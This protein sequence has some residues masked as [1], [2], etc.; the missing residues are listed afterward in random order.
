MARKKKEGGRK[1]RGRERGSKQDGGRRESNLLVG[2]E[3]EIK[4]GR[5]GIKEEKRESRGCHTAVIMD[6]ALLRMASEQFAR[7]SPEQRAA[8]QAQMANMDPAMSA[9]M[10]DK[11]SNMKKDDINAAMNQMHNMSPE[12]MATAAQAA[13]VQS[14]HQTQY[15]FRA[16]EQLKAE[17]NTL[18][19]SGQY[20]EATEK[21]SRAIRN[22]EGNGS[23]EAKTLRRMCQ[24]NSASCFLKLSKF[25]DVDTICTDVLKIEP[26]NAKAL[27]RRAQ[28]RLQLNN[29]KGSVTDFEAALAASPGDETISKALQNARNLLQDEDDNVVTDDTTTNSSD[30]RDGTKTTVGGVTIEELSS[31]S[32][33]PSK[34]PST[35]NKS[36]TPTTSTSF[37]SEASESTAK[38]DP[39]VS[40][41]SN[42]MASP[43]PTSTGP[44]PSMMESQMAALRQNPDM[45]KNMGQMM[46]DMSPEQL[47]NI[48]SMAGQHGGMGGMKIDPSMMKMAAEMMS[49]MRPDEVESMMKMQASMQSTEA[50]NV[51]ASA[52][53]SNGPVATEQTG[54][55]TLDNMSPEMLAQME[56]QMSDPQNME[57]MSSMMQN[58]SPETLMYA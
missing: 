58:M 18:F 19:K 47:E 2:E 45:L 3:Q 10:F 53:P 27:Y 41:P 15:K 44:S 9:Q 14:G 29:I 31:P 12:Q 34:P 13:N 5:E 22:L 20:N 24:V 50:T 37:E 30:E 16:S 35:K 38:S 42:P 28:A 36:Q 46:K 43:I 54:I 4:K 57:A 21:Y 40:L 25:A 52:G 11:V 51:S 55:G 23:D 8:L 56:K 1:Q 39:V 17:G 7:M 33:K 49:N 48:A 32:S 6:P 26:T